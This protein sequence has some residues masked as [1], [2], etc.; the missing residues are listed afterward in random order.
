MT[1][2]LAVAREERDRARQE[3]AH[4]E[5]EAQRLSGLLFATLHDQEGT[6]HG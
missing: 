4:H 2:A 6:A 1:R 5:R 3:A